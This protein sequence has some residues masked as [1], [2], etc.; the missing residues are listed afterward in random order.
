MKQLGMTLLLVVSPC[1]GARHGSAQAAAP[2][3]PTASAV[4]HADQPGPVI[5]KNIYGHFAE[6]L[7][8]CIYEGI[9]VGPGLAHPQHARHPQRRRRGPEGAQAS[10]S[11]AGRAAASPT[12]T[13]GRT[14]SAR[15]RSARR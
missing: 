6:H 2:A 3:G 15:A 9:W 10:R 14:A 7:G 1:I 13:T 4:L 11:C 5:N 12:N 8:R